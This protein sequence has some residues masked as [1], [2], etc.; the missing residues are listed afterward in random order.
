[1]NNIQYPP[2][3]TPL[4]TTT[5]VLVIDQVEGGLVATGS[6]INLEVNTTSQY[7]PLI[8][9]GA[10]FG[11]LCLIGVIS[12]IV[13]ILVLI[14][15]HKTFDEYPFFVIVWHLTAANA[16][17]VTCIITSILPLMLLD[18]NDDKNSVWYTWAS[19]IMAVSEQAA[20]YLTLLMTIN[21]FVV[22]V[23]PSLVEY[24]SRRNLMIMAI[25]VWLYVIF[26]V[27]WNVIYG[28]IKVFSKKRLSQ[29]TLVDQLLGGNILTQFF[30]LSFTILPI[31]M[32]IMYGIIVLAIMNKRSSTDTLH[33][34]ANKRD[35][36]FLWQAFV[37]TLALELTNVTGMFNFY[38]Q[39]KAEI[40]QWIYTIF[41]YSTSIFN[42]I[43]NPVISLTC[44][45]MIR[46]TFIK[47][48]NREI[49]SKWVSETSESP[50]MATRSQ[51]SC[52]SRFQKMVPTKRSASSRIFEKCHHV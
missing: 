36:S 4:F 39:D 50:T 37:I 52:L 20:L 18:L 2:T 17:H 24:F 47:I 25:I 49:S 16:I 5:P 10:V 41:N 33:D 30:N 6:I 1:M 12:I 44:N 38:F 34:K 26:I 27:V 28:T 32:L 3:T 8:A 9:A 51:T 46:G 14:L 22:F 7:V 15:G 19:R 48:F 40:L 21:R 11:T 45:R 31:I 23:F 42:Q 35:R 13:F 43:V 29:L